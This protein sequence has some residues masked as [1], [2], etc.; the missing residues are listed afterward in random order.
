MN[1]M[2]QYHIP[3]AEE[4][5]E[6]LRRKATDGRTCPK[7]RS[8]ETYQRSGVGFEDTRKCRLCGEVY[9]VGYITL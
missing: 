8:R 6:E 2:N 7:C 3:T 4:L 9:D 1:E 5:A